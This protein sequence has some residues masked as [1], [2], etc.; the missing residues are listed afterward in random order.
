MK[1]AQDNLKRSMIGQTFLNFEHEEFNPIKVHINQ[2]YGI[3]INDFA[4][5]VAKTALWIADGTGIATLLL[6]ELDFFWGC[7]ELC[8]LVYWLFYLCK[9]ILKNLLTNRELCAII[10]TDK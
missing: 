6:L 1:I 3:E 2:F 5:T 8:F 10:Q 4:V 9:I 7:L